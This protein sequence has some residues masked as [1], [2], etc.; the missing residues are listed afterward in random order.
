MTYEEQTKI[1]LENKKIIN[2]EVTGDRVY[3]KLNDGTVF[4]Y[5]ASDG[6]YSSWEVVK[7]GDKNE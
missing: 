7:E 5:F 6:G 1:A 4:D 3:L 2:A